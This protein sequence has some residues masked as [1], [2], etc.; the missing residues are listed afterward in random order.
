MHVLRCTGREQVRIYR[1]DGQ[2]IIHLDILHITH[3]NTKE[4]YQITKEMIMSVPWGCGSVNGSE[5]IPTLKIVFPHL[6]YH[7]IVT[8]RTT[9]SHTRLTSIRILFLSSQTVQ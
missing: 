6:L 1:I 8:V 5:Y 3:T 4:G 7:A 9:T 2:V